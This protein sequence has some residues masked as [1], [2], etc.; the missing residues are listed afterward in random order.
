M[1]T[2]PTAPDGASR[3]LGTP[4]AV[5][6]DAAARARRRL[7]PAQGPSAVRAAHPPGGAQGRARCI[8]LHA[9]ARRLADAGGADASPR[10]R[11][12]GS[13][14]LADVAAAVGAGQGRRRA[15]AGRGRPTRRKAIAAALLS[16]ERKAVLLGNAAAQHPQAG[17]AARAGATGSPSRPAP[18]VGYLG[19]A[20]NSVGAQ[21]VGAL[22]RRGRARR[23]PD[24]R[25][26]RA[27]QGLPA[28]ERRA[29][30]RRRRPGRARA[31]RWQ[32]PRWSSR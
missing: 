12:A 30:A 8:S 22:P 5:A 32:R 14:A 20:A 3:W 15:G 16:G 29:G 6:V 27:A 26:R 23:R 21:L 9:A 18:R 10:R 2:S 24:A 1:P 19:E 7:V 4:I 28:A 13:Q 17:A 25:R 31:P 11:A